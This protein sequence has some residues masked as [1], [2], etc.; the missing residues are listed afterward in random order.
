MIVIGQLIRIRC[1][2]QHAIDRQRRHF[3]VKILAEHRRPPNL[4]RP[5]VS[6]ASFRSML[7]ISRR[8]QMT[9][10]QALTAHYNEYQNKDIVFISQITELWKFSYISWQGI[11]IP[12]SKT[13]NNQPGENRIHPIKQMDIFSITSTI[14]IYNTPSPYSEQ[15]QI[16][17][18]AAFSE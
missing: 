8:H 4:P 6:S 7:D 12:F 15:V 11:V 14:P 5:R 10:I 18:L 9:C 16:Q 1:I 13:R 3:Q 17:V 2:R